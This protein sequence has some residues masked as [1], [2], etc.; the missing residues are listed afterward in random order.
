MAV[1]NRN[2]MLRQER[3][4]DQALLE[5]GGEW[6]ADYGAHPAE[7]VAEARAVGARAL[8]F[9]GKDVSFLRELPDLEFL[10]LGDCGDVTPAMSLPRLRGFTVVSWERGLIDASAWP[11]LERFAASEP[12]KGGGGV[13]TA[14]GHPE[15]RELAL[16]RFGMADLTSIT[17]PRL[18]QL[19]VSG[20]KLA[21]LRGIERLTGLEVLTLSRVPKLASLAGVETLPRLEILALDGARQVTTLDH[22][23]QIPAL[24][25][26]DIGDQK[27]IES[28]APLA[29]HPTL[30]FVN[31]QRTVDMSLAPLF[32]IPRLRGVFG[33][34]SSKWD[35]DLDDLPVLI[36]RPD[37]DPANLAYTE[38]R[39][40]Y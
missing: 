26:L 20:A 16:G 37:D 2:E 21:S 10:G 6:I 32:E 25:L 17:A 19:Y 8:S 35:R 40:R 1:L 23:A 31:F 30:E 7:I 29:G 15:V 27:G 34:H 36:G 28:F 4:V 33:Y 14:Y 18:R 5:V 24:R 13:H 22:V 38:L 9:G 3:P 11:H 39:T 12:P